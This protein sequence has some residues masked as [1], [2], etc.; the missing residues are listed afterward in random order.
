[1]TFDELAELDGFERAAELAV[2]ATH[3]LGLPDLARAWLRGQSRQL[4]GRTPLEAADESPAW[5]VRAF[6]LLEEL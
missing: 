2:E 5:A 1:M 4:E 3:R 6:A